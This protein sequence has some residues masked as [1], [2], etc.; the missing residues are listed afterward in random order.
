MCLEITVKLS[1]YAK[2]QVAP[3]G[4]SSEFGLAVRKEHN[5]IGEC[6]HFSLDGACS[7][8]LMKK[9]VSQEDACFVLTQDA[10]GRLS[11]AV[12]KIGVETKG[13]MF[14]AYWLGEDVPLPRRIKLTDLVKL[15][16]ENHIPRSSAYVVGN[17]G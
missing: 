13:F 5:D 14:R 17:Y 8:D 3:R 9:G 10:A 11:R 15:I 16:A 1:K 4:L 12:R 6:L 2:S 7:C